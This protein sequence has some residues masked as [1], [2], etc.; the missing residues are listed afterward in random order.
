M[1]PS[2]AAL[3]AAALSVHSS[4]E[5]THPNLKENRINLKFNNQTI[6]HASNV[7]YPRL[8]PSLPPQAVTPKSKT[9]SLQAEKALA[10][11]NDVDAL[12]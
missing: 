3:A 2:L 9:N 6:L 12:V 11:S 5:L 4:M 10:Y 7:M 8:I 1:I